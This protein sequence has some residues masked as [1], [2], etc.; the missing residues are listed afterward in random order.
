MTDKKIALVTG[1]TR[2]IGASISK[3][4]QKND[5]HVIANYNSNDEAAQKFK[6]ESGAD[7]IK[8]DVGNFD[9]T[10]QA[11]DSILKQFGKIDVLV[12]NAGITKDVML[13]KMTENDWDSVLNT[14][15]KSAFNVTKAVITSMRERGFGRVI[16]ISSING[17]KG[18]IGQTNYCAA[19]AGLIGFTKALALEG[20]RKNITANVICPGYIETD[21]TAAVPAEIM[22]E[23]VKSIP[24]GRLGK[25]EEI[26]ALV[27][28][29]ASEHGA[30]ITGSVLSANGGQ[31]MP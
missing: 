3:Y 23:I 26:G 16:N 11:V 19:K 7:V 4:L 5:Y 13:H 8:F 15:L 20:A 27:A 29:L 25:P 28:F 22:S 17:Q 9:Q 2:G 1:G 31:Y 10:Q 18:Q 21:M 30:F 6:A 14:N 12:N 24:V